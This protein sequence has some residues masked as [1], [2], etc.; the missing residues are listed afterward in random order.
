M[1]RPGLGEDVTKNSAAKAAI[2]GSAVAGGVVMGPVGMV[3]GAATAAAAAIIYSGI[4]DD[5][6]ESDASQ[7]IKNTVGLQPW[8]DKT[9]GIDGENPW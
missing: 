5:R 9:N 4:C 7:A 1:F 8:G 3:V 2:W 6:S